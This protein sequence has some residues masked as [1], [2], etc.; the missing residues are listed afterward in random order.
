MP[1]QS[2]IQQAG[3]KIPIAALFF[4][5]EHHGTVINQNF[6]QYVWRPRSWERCNLREK[7]TVCKK[8]GDCLCYLFQIRH[9]MIDEFWGEENDHA[10]LGDWLTLTNQHRRE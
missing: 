1:V 9:T 5:E 7:C 10:E 4:A 8:N 3:L 2:L 6:I